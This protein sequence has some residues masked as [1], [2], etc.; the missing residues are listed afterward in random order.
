MS[1][2]DTDSSPPPYS[3]TPP[4][5]VTLAQ[6]QR[7]TST[8]QIHQHPSRQVQYRSH[9]S[10]SV[11]LTPQP[12]SSTLSSRPQTNVSGD[13]ADETSASEDGM[14]YA[15]PSSL[16]A[17]LRSRLLGRQDPGQDSEQLRP[18]TTASE[19]AGTTETETESDSVTAQPPNRPNH[20]SGPPSLRAFCVS[21]WVFASLFVFSRLLS[22]VPAVFGTIW[23]IYHI[24]WPPPSDLGPSALSWRVDYFIS[25]LWAILTGWQCLQLTTGVLKRWRVYYSP[26]ATLIRLFALQAICWPATHLTLKLLNHGQRP[27][28]CWA[29]I[30][31]TTCYSRS[32]QL[33]VTSNIG[34]APAPP[35]RP[36]QPPSPSP[37]RRSLVASASGMREEWIKLRRRRWDW[38]EV[39]RKCVLPAGVIYFVMAWAD[40]LRREW[41]LSVCALDG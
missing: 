2:P 13:E 4:S 30:G 6:L 8:P 9:P 34:P 16:A 41:E 3:P 1:E 40:M 38:N 36:S 31:T 12:L 37:L 33:W 28:L 7:T 14:I 35:P 26:F 17:S 23:N 39:I 21:P 22:I 24:R 29:V 10:S 25:V 27:A 5:S 11:A 15:I 18:I 19:V 32:I 20:T